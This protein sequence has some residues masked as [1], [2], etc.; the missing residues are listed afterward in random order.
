[1]AKI[2]TS[3]I[4]GYADMTAEQKIAAIEA[5][6][7]AEPDYSGFVKKDVFDTKAKEAAELSRKLKEKMTADEQAEANRLAE[8]ESLKTELETLRKE[9]TVSNY[10]ASYLALGYDEALASATAEALA[11]GKTDVVFANQKVFIEAQQKV[12]NKEVLK[13]TPRPPAGEPSGGVTTPTKEQFD[14]MG[15]AERLK[16]HNEQPEL[17]KELTGGTE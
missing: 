2:D 12:L 11:D 5:Y 15:Y 4:E 9:R 8:A 14:A 6:E 7:I 13:G 1:M 17:Y 3:K 16:L 10:K